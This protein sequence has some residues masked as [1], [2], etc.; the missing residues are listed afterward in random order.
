MMMITDNADI[1]RAAL[2][3]CQDENETSGHINQ[4]EG[5]DPLRIADAAAAA[6]VCC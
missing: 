3:S 4:G 2:Q 1:Q 6:A 5:A